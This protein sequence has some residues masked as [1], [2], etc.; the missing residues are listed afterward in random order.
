MKTAM[1]WGASGGIGRSLTQQLTDAGWE[2][3]AITRYP[4][5]IEEVATVTVELGNVGNAAEIDKAIYTAQF[6]IDAIDLWVYA[7]GDIT[8]AKVID[9]GADTWQQ[10][11]GANLTGAYL[12]T[13][14]SEPLLQPDAHLFFLGAVSERLQL[15]SL[16]AYVA[17]KAGL[18]AFVA[19]L[20]KEQRKRTFTIVRPGA[21]DTDF[22]EKVSLR[23]PKDAADP[24][25]VAQR[26]ITAYENGTKG[27]L[28]ITH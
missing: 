24:D 9:M 25:K 26:I 8:Q 28:D 13:K 16:S 5:K 27:K 12:A 22:W 4:E 17:A 6:E 7:I 19:T 3:V 23:K 15:P 2:V 21:V 14:A 20:A 11:L 18:E 1:I 10:I